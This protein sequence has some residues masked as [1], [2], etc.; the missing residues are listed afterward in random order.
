MNAM[1]RMDLMN[2]MIS[3]KAREAIDMMSDDV[4]YLYKEKLKEKGEVKF[5]VEVNDNSL[6]VKISITNSYDNILLFG[7]DVPC[8]HWGFGT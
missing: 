7:L 5:W 8:G 4:Y 6:A 2:I 1:Q 3:G